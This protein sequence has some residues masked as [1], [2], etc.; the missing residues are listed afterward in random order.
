[1]KAVRR[2]TVTAT[3]R[4]AWM[5]QLWSRE[6]KLAYTVRLGGLA[7]ATLTILIGAVMVFAGLQGSFDWAVEAPHTVSAKLTNASPGIIF[8]TIGMV[9]GFVVVIQKPIRFQTGEDGTLAIHQ[10]LPFTTET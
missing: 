8:A 10:P 1:M 7:L 2:A 9:L 3:K 4:A 5:A 6:L